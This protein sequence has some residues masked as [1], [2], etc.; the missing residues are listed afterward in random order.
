[1][2][3]QIVKMNTENKDDILLVSW[4]SDKI[5]YELSTNCSEV[6][7]EEILLNLGYLYK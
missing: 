6:E 5:M 3:S 7:L 1:M 4:C 2:Y